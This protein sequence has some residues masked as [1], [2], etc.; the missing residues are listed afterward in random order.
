LTV[1]TSKITPVKSTPLKQ[2]TTLASPLREHPPTG[3][4]A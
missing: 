3:R 4:Y 1:K 2:K